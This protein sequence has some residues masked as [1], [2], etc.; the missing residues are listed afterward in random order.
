MNQ[1]GCTEYS[2]L[3]RRI[4][5]MEQHIYNVVTAYLEKRYSHLVTRYTRDWPRLTASP[6]YPLADWTER[7]S[8]KTHWKKACSVNTSMAVHVPSSS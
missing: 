7:Q 5:R 1:D 6:T 8:I 2:Q 4:P 3:C